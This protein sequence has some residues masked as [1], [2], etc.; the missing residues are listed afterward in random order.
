M[1][2]KHMRTKDDLV[3]KGG[4]RLVHEPRQKNLRDE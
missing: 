4:K 2:L 3:H 1:I